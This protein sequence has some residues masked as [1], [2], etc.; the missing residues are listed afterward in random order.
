[1]YQ[2][3]F[4]MAIHPCAK[5]GVPVSKSKD[6]LAKTQMHGENLILILRLKV[7]FKQKSW[8]YATHYPMVTY[9]C[10]RYGMTMS[11]DFVKISCGPNKKLCQKLYKFDLEVK[12][13]CLFGIM[14]V[15]DTSSH[16]DRPMCRICYANVKA[17]IFYYVLSLIEV[18]M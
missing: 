2:T 10:A 9:S 17:N 16:C 4:L 8:M 7:K 12:G 15:C 14:N 6:H 3:C 18:P 1:M 5:F 13:Q 11:K